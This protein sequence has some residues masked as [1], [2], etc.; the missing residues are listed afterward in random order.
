[1]I[2]TFGN[3]D[4]DGTGEVWEYLDL[5]AYKVNGEWMYGGVNC[6]DGSLSIENS[7]CPYPIC[8]EVGPNFQN[9]YIPLGWSIMSTHM[10]PENASVDEIFSPIIEHLIILKDYT[11]LHIPQFSFNGIGDIQFGY[12]YSL[13]MSSES[14]VT[15][16]GDYINPKDNPLTIINGWSIIGYLRTTSSPLDAIFESMQKL[17]NYCQ[18]YMGNAYIPSFN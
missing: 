4:V 11:E 1:M 17:N 12:G 14:E 6:T 13:K 10:T 5:W 8:N 15:I 16:H 9:I 2:E 18:D 7:S 3:V